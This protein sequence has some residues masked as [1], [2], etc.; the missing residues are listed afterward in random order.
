M[1]FGPCCSKT[2][3]SQ[4]Q[5]IIPQQVVDAFAAAVAYSINTFPIH[6]PNVFFKKQK[7]EAQN[8]Q[9]LINYT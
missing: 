6:H 7:K 1:L 3:M 2:S 8:P 9:H 4:S 5:K